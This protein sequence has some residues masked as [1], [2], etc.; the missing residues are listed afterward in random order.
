MILCLGVTIELPTVDG[1]STNGRAMSRSQKRV[2][3]SYAAPLE[4]VDIAPCLQVPRP[5]QPRR[6]PNPRTWRCSN[7]QSIR[8]HRVCRSRAPRCRGESEIARTAALLA[9]LG[10]RPMDEHNRGMFA[11]SRRRD[12]HPGQLNLAIREPHVFTLFDLSGTE[13]GGLCTLVGT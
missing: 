10:T 2:Q 7:R 3:R 6:P 9:M 4:S 5:R 8:R 13:A 12:Q 11:T 1:G